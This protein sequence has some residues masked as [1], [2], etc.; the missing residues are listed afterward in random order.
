[1]LSLQD[2][3][4]LGQVGPGTMMGD[5]LRRFWVPFIEPLAASTG[6]PFGVRS[7]SVLLESDKL[8]KENPRVPELIA[9]MA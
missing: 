9:A 4:I 8:F 1:M 7:L 2:N 6:E 5:L 3:M